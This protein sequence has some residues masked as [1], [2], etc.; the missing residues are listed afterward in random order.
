[1]QQLE[2]AAIKASNN[3]INSSSA[4]AKGRAIKGVFTFFA[5]EMFI[6]D[7]VSSHLTIVVFHFL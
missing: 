6:G 1:M 4:E 3:K 5:V 7:S 2:Q